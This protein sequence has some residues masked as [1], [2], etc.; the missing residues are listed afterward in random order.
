MNNV[1]S[2]CRERNIFDDKYIRAKDLSK[3][4]IGLSPSTF[5]GWARKGLL[6]SYKIEG[7]KFYKLSEVKDLIENSKEVV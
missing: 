5:D 3:I 7:S 6:C 1:V 4:F 2:L